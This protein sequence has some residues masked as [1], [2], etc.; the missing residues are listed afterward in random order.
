M[1]A[2][3]F[4]AAGVGAGGA[5][6]TGISKRPRL[7]A[8]TASADTTASPAAHLPIIRD[9][10]QRLRGAVAVVTNVPSV[11]FTLPAVTLA[12]S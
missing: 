5:F 2:L 8:L 9:A 1:V 3:P 10:G 12:M 11:A 7:G 6:L 4:S